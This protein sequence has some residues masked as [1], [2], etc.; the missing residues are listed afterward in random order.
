[1]LEKSP[2]STPRESELIHKE[3]T[4]LIMGCAMEVHSVPGSGFQERGINIA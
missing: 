4:Y 3:L 1:M 2:T